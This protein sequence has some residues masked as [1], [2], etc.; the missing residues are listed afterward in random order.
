MYNTININL[1]FV[2]FRFVPVVGVVQNKFNGRKERTKRNGS[3]S[4]FPLCG[5]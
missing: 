2:K 5:L 1:Q 3:K 4:W